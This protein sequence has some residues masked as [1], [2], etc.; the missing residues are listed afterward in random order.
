MPPFFRFQQ[1]TGKALYAK[2]TSK[3]PQRVKPT[4]VFGFLH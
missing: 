2:K 1:K 3:K 4:A